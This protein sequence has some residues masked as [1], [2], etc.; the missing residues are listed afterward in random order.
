MKNKIPPISV[1]KFFE[2]Y[3]VDIE[4]TEVNYLEFFSKTIADIKKMA[5]GPYFSYIFNNIKMRRSWVSE[6][7]EQFTPYSKEE[8]LNSDSNF[9]L[10]LF[11]PDDAFYLLGAFDFAHK[12]GSSILASTKKSE[13]CFNFYGRMLNY[14]GNYRWILL[15]SPQQYF[16][17]NNQLEAV[18][19]VITDLSHFQIKSMPLLSMMDHRKKE[20]QYF[21]HFRQGRA[22]IDIKRPNITKREK[23][24]L[25]LMAKGFNTPQIAEELSISYHTVER[26][27][28]NLR[29]KTKTKTAAELIAYTMAHSLLLL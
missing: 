24:V 27:K 14:E 15:Q 19:V 6:N 26:H 7:I 21:K 10:N 1:D 20:M 11:H 13:I 5:I 28:D 9:C 17:N 23:E 8:W 4:D 2:Q 22:E 3:K 18:L 12:M 16:N 25:T 29:A